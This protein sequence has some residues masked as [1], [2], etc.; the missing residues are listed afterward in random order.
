VEKVKNILLVK[1][2]K[3]QH[4]V[5]AIGGEVHITEALTAFGIT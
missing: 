5:D 1:K 3:D 2:V 4:K